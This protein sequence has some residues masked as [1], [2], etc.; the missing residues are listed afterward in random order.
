MSGRIAKRSRPASSAVSDPEIRRRELSSFIEEFGV[1]MPQ[2]SRCERLDLPCHF[3]GRKSSRC[4]GCVK[5]GVSSCDVAGPSTNDRKG[6]RCFMCSFADPLL[7]QRLRK[8]KDK[9]DDEEEQTLAKLLRLRK[10]R[11]KLQETAASLIR[12]G[13]RSI[14][15]LERAEKAEK[16]VQASS[17]LDPVVDM[18]DWDVSVDPSF[19]VDFGV[20]S[21]DSAAG[22]DFVRRASSGSPEVH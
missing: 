2:C 8:E 13:L 11:R 18:Q 3:D 17:S 6:V 14:E 9:L 1:I 12:R 21:S 7:V 19:F 10:Q 4:S 15:E 20:G 5:A 22:G 16:E